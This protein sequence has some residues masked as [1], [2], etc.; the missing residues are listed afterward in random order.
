MLL[1]ASRVISRSPIK[2]KDSSMTVVRASADVVEVSGLPAGADTESI[3]LLL[4]S[5][6]CGWLSVREVKASQQA[7][8]M[9]AILTTD[10][11]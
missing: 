10:D 9:Y 4:E 8:T 3:Q 7:D 1:V 6:K 11:G 2:Y 5:R